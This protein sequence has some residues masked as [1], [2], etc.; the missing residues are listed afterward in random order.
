MKKIVNKYEI[1]AKSRERRM[2]GG[3][4]GIITDVLLFNASYVEMVVKLF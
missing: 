4:G 3:G 1:T 2:V